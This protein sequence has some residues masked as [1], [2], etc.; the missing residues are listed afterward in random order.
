MTNGI[1]FSDRNYVKS[2]IAS[3]LSSVNIGLNHPSYNDHKVIRRKQLEAI[4]NAH[5]EG[6]H[7][8]YISYTMMTLG[9]VDFIMNEIC[10]NEWRSKNFRIRY[11]SDI[12]RNPGQVRIFVSDVYKAIEQWCKDNIQVV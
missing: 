9:E 7:I 4:H 12:G 1:R 5:A 10:S 2:A 3:G 11:G 6:L 8:S